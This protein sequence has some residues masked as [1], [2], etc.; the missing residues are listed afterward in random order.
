MLKQRKWMKENL[1]FTLVELIIVMGI[2]GIV[3]GVFAGSIGYIKA[4][5]TKKAAAAVNNK[6]GYA[7]TETMAKKGKEI[8]YLFT[9]DGSGAFDAGVYVICINTEKEDFTKNSDL[10]SSSFVQDNA[11]KVASSRVTASA[12]VGGSG[13]VSLTNANMLRMEFNKAT[14]AFTGS[15]LYT[16]SGASGSTFYD[17]ITLKGTETFK[18]ELVQASG[19][20]YVE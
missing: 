1:G 13:N 18:V 20:H 6:L 14:G 16:D 15:T 19:K 10:R 7:Q 3:A 9:S 4:G 2:M 17:S 8:V 12:T 11:Q 5:K